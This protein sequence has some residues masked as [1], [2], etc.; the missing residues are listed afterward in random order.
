MEYNEYFDETHRIFRQ[1]VKQF[2]DKE[3]LPFVDQ[4]ELDGLFPIELYQKAAKADLLGIGYPAKLGGIEAGV[5]TKVVLIEELMR[6]GSGGLV[7]SLFSLDIALP[8]IVNYAK[9]EV[10]QEVVPE[11]LSGQAICALAITEPTGGSDVANLKTTAVKKTDPS[12]EN[13]YLVNGNKCFITSGQRADYYTVAVR[14]GDKGFSG[15]SLLVV[16]AKLEGFSVGK[17]HL[18]WVGMHLIRRIY[19]LTMLRCQQNIYWV[20]KTKVLS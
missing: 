18:K 4:W 1:S 6:A 3:V 16:P 13:Y 8:P 9:E 2:V 5:W 14:T 7:A 17:P 15:I 12:G 11:V 19:F 10:L 20:K